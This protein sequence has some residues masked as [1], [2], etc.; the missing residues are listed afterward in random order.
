MIA[1]P[2]PTSPPPVMV[3]SSLCVKPN[4]CPQSLRIAPRT[5]N[6]I[7]AAI[8]VKKL[9][10]N[11][12]FSFVPGESGEFALTSGSVE[13]GGCE[14][15]GVPGE[16][17]NRGGYLPGKTN[18]EPP[19]GDSAARFNPSSGVGHGSVGVAHPGCSLLN[20]ARSSAL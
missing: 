10:Q 17:S 20:S 1:M 12:I 7:P 15:E 6:P 3:P 19:D 16:F 18:A 14:S 2:N 11:R 13:D 5:E 9:A 4:C 8:S